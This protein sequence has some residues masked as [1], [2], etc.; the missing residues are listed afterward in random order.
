VLTV[1][2]RGCGDAAIEV[3]VIDRGHGIS[4]E[5]RQQ[6]FTPFYTTKTEGMGMGLNICRSIIEFH[7][8]RLIVDE[9]PEGGTIFSFTLPTETASERIARSA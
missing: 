5:G 7:D 6:L 2:V 9:N 8:G 4:E 3:A 1:R